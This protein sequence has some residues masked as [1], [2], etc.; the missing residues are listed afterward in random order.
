ML[1]EKTGYANFKIVDT[2][3]GKRFYVQNEDFLTPFQ[4]KQMSTQ[5]D[6]IIEYAHYL[7]EH[8]TSQGH[9]NLAVYVESYASLNGRRSQ[10]YIDP[11]IDLMTLKN[12]FSNRSFILPLNE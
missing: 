8:F 11:E 3:T 2:Q 1:M 5:A 9:Q 6:F 10:P 12:N 4:Q 7:G